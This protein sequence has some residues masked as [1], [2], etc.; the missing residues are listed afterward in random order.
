MKIIKIKNRTKINIIKSIFF[1]AISFYMNLSYKIMNVIFIIYLLNFSFHSPLHIGQV[2]FPKC[3]WLLNH[4]F[5]Q[6]EWNFFLQV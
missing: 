1:N 3:C 5:I 4:S 2:S 6:K